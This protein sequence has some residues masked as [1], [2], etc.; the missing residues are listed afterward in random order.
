MPTTFFPRRARDLSGGRRAS[1]RRLVAAC[2]ALFVLALGVAPAMLAA[3]DAGL[4]DEV[5]LRK[6]EVVPPD[7]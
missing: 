3:C 7:L 1:G 6:G 4:R 2:L 5:M